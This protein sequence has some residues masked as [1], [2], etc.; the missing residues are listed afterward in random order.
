M[1]P[2]GQRRLHESRVCLIGCGGLGCVLADTLVRAGV[3]HLRI[4]DRD[5]VEI[6][7]LQRQALF[8]ESDVEANLP[9]A[10][11]ARIKLARINSTVQVEA[12]VLDVN[13]TNIERLAAGAHLL[14]DGTDNFETRYL[15]NDLAVRSQRPW[16][17]GA[18]VGTTGLCMPVIPGDGPCLRCV[19]EE[20]PPLELSPTCDTAGVLGSAVNVV[21]SLQATEA[22]KILT[23]HIGDLHRGLTSIDLWSGRWVTLHVGRTPRA[24][25]PC[26]TERR[27]EY[28]DGTRL[29]TAVSLCGRNAVQI[30]RT[31]GGAVDFAAMAAKLRGVAS[32]AMRCN[33]FMLQASIAGFELTLFCDGRALIQGT[34]DLDVAKAVYA[35]YVGA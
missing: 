33:R 25:C 23:G 2:A 28:L 27:F 12:A 19:F 8:D 21:A 13:H 31:G 29:A 18:V 1:G 34:A 32:G 15:I 26:C 14:L 17:Y 9:K 11:A 5:F 24:G 4:C 3:G 16:V 35:K 22:L 10:E 6:D 20:P 7:N 30:N